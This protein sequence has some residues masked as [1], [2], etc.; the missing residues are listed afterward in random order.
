LLE[1]WCE[2]L[3][4]KRARA[5][6]QEFE[7]D[8]MANLFSLHER[9]RTMEYRHGPYEAFTISDP[10]TRN[11]HKASV[12]DRVLHRAVYRKL[13]PFFDRTFIADSF[14][15]RLDK[16]THRALDRFA[17]FARKA[18]ANHTK[19][20]WVLKCD[21]RKFFASIDQGI[22]LGIL[23]DLIEDKRIILLLERIVRS[24]DAG[25]AGVGLPLGNLTS[26]LFA[27]V[28]LNELDQFAKHF[29]QAKHYIRYADDFAALSQDRRYLEAILP[30]MNNFLSE[31]LSLALHSDKVYIKT[32]AS[33]V[34]FLGWVHFSDHRV[35]RTATKKR[36]FGAVR[37]GAG[38]AAIASYRGMLGHGNAWKLAGLID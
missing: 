16:G 3:S 14:S 5:D 26:Q 9:L 19:T 23:D 4:G 38:E 13:Y 25:T 31:R 15:C 11:I 35:L 17:A 20:V 18:S 8:L 28:Y 10:K 12:T 2:F 33:G 29:L 34:D 22:L 24:F 37:G 1:A 30:L 21:I 7:R 27:N 32:V 6:V 36:M